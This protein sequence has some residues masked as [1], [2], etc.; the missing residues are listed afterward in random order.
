[1]GVEKGLSRGHGVRRSTLRDQMQKGKFDVGNGFNAADGH[2]DDGTSRL[3]VLFWEGGVLRFF[4][5]QR[6]ANKKN[7]DCG[8][9]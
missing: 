1:M 5:E 4:I 9:I 3:L 8:G 6:R 7:E 2:D